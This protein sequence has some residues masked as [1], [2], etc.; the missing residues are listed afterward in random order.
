MAPSDDEDF[1]QAARTLRIELEIDDRFCPDLIFV[2]DELK[3]RGKIEGY[4]RVPDEAMK[5]DAS[6]DSDQRLL[7]IRES[8]F[9]VLDHPNLASRQ[10]F[11]RARFTIAHE[12]GHVIWSHH[13]KY[14]RGPT[15]DAATGLS[16]RLRLRESEANRFAAAFLIPS[17][18]AKPKHD[19][20][21]HR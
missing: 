14:F 8:V 7:R 16:R 9:R 15:T 17:Y 11:Q 19:G 5:D 20:G 18:L 2:L 13:G 10:E 4:L 21:A 6:Y 1:E 3:R 12:V